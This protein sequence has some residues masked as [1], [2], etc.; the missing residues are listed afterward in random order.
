MISYSPHESILHLICGAKHIGNIVVFK[1]HGFIFGKGKFEFP[2]HQVGIVN[3]L[4]FLK[5]TIRKRGC[6]F[7]G[8]KGINFPPRYEA[9]VT[10]NDVNLF[11]PSYGNI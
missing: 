3:F 6:C 9:G 8:K 5:L 1:L 4:L 2:S 7:S 10:S 11:L